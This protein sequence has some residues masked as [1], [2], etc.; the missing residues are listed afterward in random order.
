[1]LGIKTLLCLFVKALQCQH[2]F[3]IGGKDIQFILYAFHNKSDRSYYYYV[4]TRTFSTL[5]AAAAAAAL[6]EFI[7]RHH[8]NKVKRKCSMRRNKLS[9]RW[10]EGLLC[11]RQSTMWLKL[12][13]DH[14]GRS[15]ATLG[16]AAA[17][18][19]SIS[20]REPATDNV[21]GRRMGRWCFYC[22]FIM[23]NCT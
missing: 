8:Q 12:R 1:M 3:K 14:M 20:I 18:A 7:A 19:H 5:S 11:L 2:S 4:C 21:I 16:V 23:S 10:R 13:C 9:S 15:P 17:P 22:M 6:E